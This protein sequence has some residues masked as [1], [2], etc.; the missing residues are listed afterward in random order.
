[1]ADERRALVIASHWD[2]RE[3]KPEDRL[4]L[5][6]PCA[7]ELTE[8]LLD[9]L[10]GDC[11]P[12]RGDGLV[13]NPRTVAEVTDALTETF[14]EASA[15]GASL[16]LGFLGHGHVVREGEFLFPVRSTPAVPAPETAYDL[17][18]GLGEL[19]LRHGGV[20]EL[21]VV[22]DACLSG[23]AA[24]FAAQHWFGSAL[25]TG[26]RIEVLTSSDGR[27]SYGLQFSRALNGLI[28][29]GDVRLDTVLCAGP[30]RQ[31]VRA[32]LTRQVPQ[33]ASYDGGGGAPTGPL[34]TWLA[35]NVAYQGELSV[36][37]GSA[38][39][40]VLL[41]PLR[42]FQPPAELGELVE[43]VR[44][45]RQV[46]VLGTMG[47]GKTTL[48]AAL[49]RAELL[50]PEA[51]DRVPAVCGVI[52][53]DSSRWTSGSVWPLLADQLKKFLPGFAAAKKAYNSTVPEAERTL[54][55]QAVAE[56]GGPLG[57]LEQ[58]E[59]VRV[60]VDGLDQVDTA[61]R[62]E[63]VHELTAL[64]DAAPEWF[65]VVATARDGVPLPDAW[66]RAPVPAP[67]EEQLR[68]YLR[69]NRATVRTQNAILR[70]AGGN[71]QATRV[72][73]GSGP[74]ARTGRVSFTDMY[75][76]TLLQLKARVPGGHGGRLDAVLVVAAA[77]GP[78][79]TLPRPLLGRAAA[80]LGG[81]AD[82]ES[83]GQVLDLLPGLVVRSPHPAGTELLGVHHPSLIEYVAE[84]ADVVSGHA[85]LCRALEKMAP[86]DRH[87]P[88]DP[89]HAYAEQAEPEHLWQAA[90]REPAL[91]ERLLECLE[92]R[93][94]P[95]ATVNRARWVAW[96]DRLAERPGPDSP[97]TLNARERAAYWT[98]K[99][100][101]YGRSRELYRLLLDD[102][103]RVLG[104][105]DPRVLQTRYRI[106][107]A[108]GEA[109]EFA[110][111]V[112][113]HRAVLDDQVRVLG[114]D[115]PRTLKNRHDIAYWVGRGGDMAEGLRLHE[116]LLQDQLR[117]LPPTD[118]AVLESRH[119][120][121]YWHGMLGRYDTALALHEDLLRDRIAV[122][123]EDHAQVLFSRFNIYKFLGESGRRQEA[124]DG[125][126]ALLPDVRR[127][128]GED[129][130]NTLL[131]R[132]NIARYTWEL[133]DPGSALGLHEELL[134]DQR[135]ALGDTHP[136]V[137][138]TRF[139]I[140]MIRA[141]LGDPDTALAELD[142]LLE[143]RLARY[144]N[145][146]HPEVIRT[147]FGQARVRA[148][149]GDVEAAAEQFRQV[150]DDRARVL[151][152]DHPDTL[153]AQAELDG[154]VAG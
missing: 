41:P 119:Y 125:Y 20:R 65:G 14:E 21:T 12:A 43:A 95:E 17:P 104:D 127:I 148:R 120:I 129:H 50:P 55:P 18:A 51:A 5:L 136:A 80:D 22:V 78:S 76:E 1:M 135:K 121:A 93:A 26:K 150:R 45:H 3:E 122:F 83:L 96:A 82:D 24:L 123:G 91:Y 44:G 145:P 2:A 88:D 28:G 32:R 141:E 61:H 138:I 142:V 110:E 58:R 100:G 75:R 37:A 4:E 57:R 130:P 48:A 133:G 63:L 69:A 35:H 6:E 97:V 60:I 131:A 9:P 53:L 98:G 66:H 112:R 85:A 40:D 86:M 81:P 147:R 10:R 99:A 25:H 29:Q 140:A 70:Q 64:A 106:A 23:Y 46:A 73:A 111:A 89:V 154:L 146:L 34:D 117:V 113:L 11:E 27:V 116:E 49:C 152:E 74:L 149:Q 8:L 102:Q 103:R 71:W 101:A 79:P 36:L 118:Q 115:D 132:L 38:D 107:Y 139:N 72:L 137:L 52:R 16:V 87:T 134:E 108:T 153:A 31:A 62:P 39:R 126:R 13:L 19:M 47:T 144:G 33:A 90:E 56:I 128:R 109:G 94:A 42:L 143:E 84:E 67:G 30:V 124:L 77:S 15:D 105:D 114:A 7:T 54:L 151:G 59:P 68:A 92:R